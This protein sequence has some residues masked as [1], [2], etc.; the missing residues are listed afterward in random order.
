MFAVGWV[1]AEAEEKEEVQWLKQEKYSV[2][3]F[4]DLRVVQNR[5]VWME[6]RIALQRS[7]TAP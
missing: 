7:G 5:D 2:F 1:F 6:R 3:S 4:L